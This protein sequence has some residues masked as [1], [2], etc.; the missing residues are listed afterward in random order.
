[1]YEAFF[2]LSARPFADRPDPA[3][4]AE[5][6]PHMGA[7]RALYDGLEALHPLF[8]VTGETGCG[9]S[10]LA[11]LMLHGL[12]EATTVGHITNPHTSVRDLT[13]WALLSFGQETAG[14]TDAELRETFALF[15]VAEYG[16]GRRCLLVVDEA[17]NLPA[18]ALAGLHEYLDLNNESDCLLQ[19][20]LVAGPRLLQTMRDP[21][22][23]PWAERL[24]QIS[25]VGPLAPD[26]TTRYVRSRLVTAGADREIFTDRAIAA[27]GLASGGVPRLI[28]AICDAALVHAFGQAR[29]SIDRDL[30]AD[31]IAQGQALGLGSLAMLAP[32]AGDDGTAPPTTPSVPTLESAPEAEPAIS[33]DL[34]AFRE[35]E[36]VAA[37]D[38]GVPGEPDLLLTATVEPIE[39]AAEFFP[40]EPVEFFPAE[41]TEVYEEEIFPQQE[42]LPAD[43]VPPEPETQAETGAEETAPAPI[44]N[45]LAAYTP[46]V[47]IA[48]SPQMIGW[49]SIARNSRLSRLGR[50]M[51]MNA[52]A[53]GSPSLRRRFLPRN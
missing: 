21:L 45:P 35:S 14:R 44:A 25:L 20:V 36:I 50:D 4:F 47:E 18:E 32:V 3:Y 26:E 30:I 40:M 24:P 22:L 2:G 43:F 23:A 15:L 12:G 46:P 16:A 27:I 41:R 53:A 39:Q 17:Q 38:G 29:S 33:N 8:V 37:T 10:M 28:N 7:L 19:I 51:A 49:P 5:S 13:R 42:N 48:P 9:K 52:R 31:V 6:E 34:A 1:M 11:Q